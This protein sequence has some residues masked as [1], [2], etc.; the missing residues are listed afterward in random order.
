M[1]RLDVW[2]VENGYFSSRQSAKRAIREG[3][4]T[5]NGSPSK[6]S[7]Q[8]SGKESILVSEDAID[9][10]IGYVKLSIL[11]GTFQNRLV[12]SKTRALDLGSSAGGFLAY[13]AEHGDT[14][15]GVEVSEEFADPLA[16]LVRKYSNI[17]VIMDDAFSL[18]PS[19]I[20]KEGE[21]DLVLVDITAE[22]ESTMKLIERF[23][24]LLKESGW[25]VAAFKAK[26]DTELVAHYTGLVEKIG[27]E[28][29]QH[30]VLHVS[31]QEFHLV[32]KRQ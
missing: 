1:T 8:V 31:R 11:N 9:H 26:P 4:V 16:E 28:N 2:L 24:N 29:I 30:I 17:S 18:E 15:V 32:A 12:T 20:A 6:P 27:F 25:M 21:L 22:P 14:V 3:N 5:V 7:K 13:L 19:I 23:A 10:P